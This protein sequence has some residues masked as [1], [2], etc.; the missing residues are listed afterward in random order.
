MGIE[1]LYLYTH[2]AQ[3]FYEKLGWHHVSNSYYE[4]QDVSIM[5]IDLT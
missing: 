5:V 2:S 4:G 1:R 3:G